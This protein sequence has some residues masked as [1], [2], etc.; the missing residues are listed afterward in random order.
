LKRAM[1]R[2]ITIEVFILKFPLLVVYMI[3]AFNITAFTVLLQLD[4]LV[5]N[6]LWEKLIAWALTI[7]AWVLAYLNRD[8]YITVF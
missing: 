2:K 8:K 6:S 3:V 4:V 1:C 7:G 5:F